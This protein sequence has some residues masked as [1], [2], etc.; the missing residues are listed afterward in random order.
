MNANQRL[1]AASNSV[2][3]TV[4][5]LLTSGLLPALQG[6]VMTASLDHRLD[7]PAKASERGRCE[8]QPRLT[9][10]YRA[11]PNANAKPTKPPTVFE[12]VATEYERQRECQPPSRETMLEESDAGGWTPAEVA[13]ILL[14]GGK[15]PESQV[16]DF[17]ADE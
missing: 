16:H 14:N 17:E 7:C 13:F 3:E 6:E 11:V 5:L 12:Q 2:G 1:I 8:C 15:W 4:E 10:T 9:I